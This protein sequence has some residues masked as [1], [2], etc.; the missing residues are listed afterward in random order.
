MFGV[1]S[2]ALQISALKDSGEIKLHVEINCGQS[3]VIYLLSVRPPPPPPFP[4]STFVT[5]RSPLATTTRAA[6]T[7]TTTMTRPK[8]SRG[9]RCITDKLRRHKRSVRAQYN[10]RSF[11]SPRLT[12]S[13]NCIIAAA[14]GRE[15]GRGREKV[16]RG[17]CKFFG[18]ARLHKSRVI[19]AFCV[20]SSPTRPPFPLPP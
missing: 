8:F 19:V 14:R 17:I 7:S 13:C 16:A 4:S 1:E 5:S 12:P 18:R 6:A 10:S 11:L 9:H 20:T 15:D 2:V 3:S